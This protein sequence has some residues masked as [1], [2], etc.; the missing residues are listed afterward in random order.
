M[1]AALPAKFGFPWMATVLL[2]DDKTLRRLNRD[3]R[4]LDRPT[5]VLSFPQFMPA[6][7]AKIGKK[8]PPLH[9]G[10][11]ALGYQYIV[12]E[13]K[14]Y[15]K[16]LIDHVTHLVVHGLLHLFGYDH[17]ASAEAGRMERLEQ[18]IMASLGLPDPYARVGREKA[19][20][21]TPRAL[22]QRIR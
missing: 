14:K 12:V 21:P 18:A 19:K 3:F 4:G 1:R 9:M 6:Q 8:G 16:I 17:I 22:K 13:A 7:L 15:H 11:I 20:K 2:A 5:N 10:D